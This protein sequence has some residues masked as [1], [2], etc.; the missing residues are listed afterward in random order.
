MENY[1]N[2]RDSGVEKL[3]SESLAA[4]LAKS[5]QSKNLLGDIRKETRR[6]NNVLKTWKI[7][8]ITKLESKLQK[9]VDKFSKLKDKVQKKSEDEESKDE[10]FD[11]DLK[12]KPKE[13]TKEK[14]KS[15]ESIKETSKQKS[16]IEGLK[17][18]L[19]KFE[20]PKFEVPKLELPKLELPKI[21]VPRGVSDTL[22][23]INRGG[24][25][26]LEG[27]AKGLTDIARV[28]SG[29]QIFGDIVSNDKRNAVKH[30]LQWAAAETAGDLDIGVSVLGAAPSGGVSLGG[31]AASAALAYS[32]AEGTGALFDFFFPEEK[33]KEKNPPKMAEG[34]IVTKPTMAIIGEGGEKEYIIPQSKLKKFVGSS[35]VNDQDSIKKPAR[36]I[37]GVV[38]NFI[39]QSGSSS[40]D[41]RRMV[42][43]DILR[44]ERIFGRERFVL[45][46]FTKG[47]GNFDKIISDSFKDLVKGRKTGGG[48]SP[49]LT[50]S[51]ASLLDNL[52]EFLSKIEKMPGRDIPPPPG[53]IDPNA[54]DVFS[55]EGAKRIW[56]FFKGKGL[57]DIAVAG[58]L[59]NSDRETNGTFDPKIRGNGMGPGGTDA[60][61]IFQWGE[62]ARFAELVSWASQKNLDPYNLDTQLQFAWYEAN[63]PYYRSV[64]SG[65]QN[66]STPT[67]AAEVWRSI[68][69]GSV[70]TGVDIT[71]RG[72]AAEKWYKK[73]QN[74]TPDQNQS[75]PASSAGA[76]STTSQ[77]QKPSGGFKGYIIV[78]GH[79]T[80]G[81]APGER[82][83]VRVLARAAYERIKQQSPSANV[84]FMD[85]NG[86]FAETDDGWKQ[87][88]NW[89]AQKQ[90]EGYQILEIHMDRESGGGRGIIYPVGVN[91]PVANAFGK[92]QGTYE[93]PVGY[94]DLGLPKRGGTIFELGNIQ[95]GKKYGQNDI[96]S[97]I[98][99]FVSAFTSSSGKTPSSVPIS[100]SQSSSAQSMTAPSGAS[101]FVM[102]A[103]GTITSRWHER[104]S[105][106]IHQGVDIAN[107]VGT[108]VVAPEDGTVVYARF[109]SGGYG[110]MVVIKGSKGYHIL[111]HLNRILTSEGKD[112]KAGQQVGEMGSTGRSTGPHLHWQINRNG[113]DDNS[114]SIDPLS[115]SPS[116]LS[117]RILRPDTSTQPTSVPSSIRNTATRTRS[118]IPSVRRLL[119][120]RA[121]MTY[122]QPVAYML[123]NNSQPLPQNT[124]PTQISS[125]GV[126]GISPILFQTRGI[127]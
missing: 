124:Q 63:K 49:Q 4:Q 71:T 13:E 122:I 55:G 101:G 44:M 93:Y 32:A 119:G 98:A 82:K 80:G 43:G 90:S 103:K 50:D 34:G 86:Q 105:N 29:L 12:R 74:A 125:A 37:L 88:L 22:S 92:M 89:F 28:L 42:G 94:R 48:L 79:A 73:F 64:I 113:I 27:P 38:N 60:I 46:I 96:N 9:D 10:D 33:K 3:A 58:I 8:D 62:R 30:S 77:Q 61:G 121:S 116:D 45:P 16:L 17:E 104:R 72:Q 123:P 52:D 107:N 54:P 68:F 57:S 115:L 114:S 83:L 35:Y 1:Q 18:K 106:E 19:P 25:K 84:Q 15:K 126:T 111:G 2:K 69:E 108:P 95:V 39:S 24:G 117:G 85:L 5:T 26:L 47:E 102:P 21:E 75:M 23:K 91:N 59:G 66:A 67:Q 53:S 127:G 56:N 14:E 87:Q 99:P 31:L 70:G 118:L 41:I 81:G 100:S 109:N 6:I 97:L 65:L 20:A 110:N 7:E 40:G 120:P 11:I 76:I 51:I 112:V 78:P 36:V